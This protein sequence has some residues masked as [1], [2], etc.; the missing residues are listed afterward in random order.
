MRTYI[1]T[2]EATGRGVYAAY[3]INKGSILE[4]EELLVLSPEDTLKVNDTDLNMYTFKFNDTQDCLV[5]GKGELY[6]HSDDA[7]VHY[8][9]MWEYDRHVM[10]FYAVKPIQEGEQLFIDYSLDRDVNISTYNKNLI[11]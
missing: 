11:G 3:E 6:N 8:K 2:E 1:K 10:V 4:K 5:L 7:N 9:L